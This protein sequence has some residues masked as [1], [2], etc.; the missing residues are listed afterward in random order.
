MFTDGRDTRPTS[1]PTALSALEAAM[2]ENHL[3]RLVSVVGR[4]FAMDRDHNWERTDKAYDLLTK[5]KG[6]RAET[7]LDAVRISHQAGTTDEFIEPIFLGDPDDDVIKEG[8]AIIFANFR[9]DRTRQL[10]ERF[11]EQGPKNIFFATMTQYHPA[12]NVAVAYRPHTIAVT[13]GGLISAQQWK[14]VRITETEKFPHVTFFM[15]CKQEEAYEGEDRIMMDSNS[16]VPTHDFKPVMRAPEITDQVVEAMIAEK[17]ELIIANI[18]NADMVGHTGN[19][20]AAITA[21]EA[22]DKALSRIEAA[23]L[24]H[25]YAVIVIAD[26]GNADQMID[27]ITGEMHTSHTLNPAPFI[28]I[29]KETKELLRN[30]GTLIDIAPTICTLLGIEVPGEMTGTSFI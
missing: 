23:A 13:L 25:D 8:D 30:S 22:V 15:N 1:S 9:N 14:Q 20:P 29:T 6:T 3:G 17:Y 5:G 28:L 18:C 24:E 26:H 7:A 27:E 16:D 2:Q 21:C 10:S 19:I 12:Y 4:Y 11:L